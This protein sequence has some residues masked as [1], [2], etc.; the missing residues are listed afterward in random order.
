MI[1][2]HSAELYFFLI[3][4]TLDH[5]YYILSALLKTPGG[6][7]HKNMVYVA[8]IITEE[9]VTHKKCRQK[10]SGFLQTFKEE[11]VLPMIVLS[12]EFIHCQGQMSCW[13]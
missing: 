11:N 8:K 9:V 6:T 3:R 13:C 4:G 10:H 1:W 12:S 7:V 2:K 5:F